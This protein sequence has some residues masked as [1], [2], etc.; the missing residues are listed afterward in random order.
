MNR[1]QLAVQKKM[2]YI[3]TGIEEGP[4]TSIEEGEL[5]ELLEFAKKHNSIW[6][7]AIRNNLD[8]LDA[9]ADLIKGLAGQCIDDIFTMTCVVGQKAVLFL[10]RTIQD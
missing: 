4:L 10:L 3:I 2:Q 5:I 6:G 7:K 8:D 9:R 1:A